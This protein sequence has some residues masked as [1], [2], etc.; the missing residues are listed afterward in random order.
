M[1][2]KYANEQ[3]KKMKLESHLEKK[4]PKVFY[5]MDINI[6]LDNKKDISIYDY[7][8]LHNEIKSKTYPS[9]CGLNIFDNTSINKKSID[10]I[11]SLG[12]KIA[13][14]CNNNMPKKTYEQGVQHANQIIPYVQKL[15]IP[16]ETAIFIRISDSDIISSEYIMG[17]SEKLVSKEYIPA[18]IVNTEKNKNFVNMFNIMT[19]ISNKK[20][21]FCLIWNTSTRQ[22]DTPHETTLHI[23]NY[24]KQNLLD[25]IRNQTVIWRCNNLFLNNIKNE[26]TFFINCLEDESVLI[27]NMF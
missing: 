6:L 15:D 22:E 19:L 16:F 4:S 8:F 26:K 1:S 27:E 17:Y 21:R 3:E 7:S 12:C 9:F 20:S 10:I 18:F 23:F 14:I 24:N 13:P 11:H 2:Y 5:G 25:P